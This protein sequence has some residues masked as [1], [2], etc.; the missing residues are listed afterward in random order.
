ML[1]DNMKNLFTEI[2]KLT[3]CPKNNICFVS[4]DGGY[5]SV[6]EFCESVFEKNQK[7]FVCINMVFNELNIPILKIYILDKM[8]FASDNNLTIGDCIS[9]LPDFELSMCCY[10]NKLDIQEL[11]TKSLNYIVY[12]DTNK[13]YTS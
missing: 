11:V 4:I 9:I 8:K 2:Y 3:G 1:T 5:N 13:I 6:I 7:I 10:I 12:G